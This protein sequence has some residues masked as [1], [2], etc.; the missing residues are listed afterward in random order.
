[1]EMILTFRRFSRSVDSILI[2]EEIPRDIHVS[3]DGACCNDFPFDI[4]RAGEPFG[5][6]NVYARVKHW[7]DVVQ[8]RLGPETGLGGM[9]NVQNVASCA[10]AAA[11]VEHFWNITVESAL[12][13]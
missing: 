2:Q 10:S 8:S 11:R 9:V 12:V 13:C 6:G 5:G 7:A 1:M 3:N 4:F